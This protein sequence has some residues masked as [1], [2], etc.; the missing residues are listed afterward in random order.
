MAIPPRYKR[1]KFNPFADG[2]VSAGQRIKRATGSNKPAEDDSDF[3]PRRHGNRRGRT[4][5][6]STRAKRAR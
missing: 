6:Y 5:T 1:S 4:S 3:D 2:G